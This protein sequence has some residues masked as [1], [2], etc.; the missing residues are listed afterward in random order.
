[1]T[2]PPATPTPPA[3]P[4]FQIIG[5]KNLSRQ[6]QADWWEAIQADRV[7]RTTLFSLREEQKTFQWWAEMAVWPGYDLN[8]VY[9]GLPASATK[10]SAGLSSAGYG[11]GDSRAGLKK[12]AYFWVNKWAGRGAYL[13]FGFL[14]AGLP[15]KMEVGRHVL[16]ILGEAGYRCLAGLTPVFNHHVVAYG[17]ALGATLMGRWPGVCYLAAR[18]EF[19]DGVLLQF[20]VNDKED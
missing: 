1:M 3:P 10:P 16:K 19:V 4:L 18:D 5:V 9:L 11:P 7:A 20:I 12:L 2:N 8:V 14:E 13:H 15:W 6:E 17:L